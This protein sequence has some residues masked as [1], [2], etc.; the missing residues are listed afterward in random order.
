MSRTIGINE[1]EAVLQ[2]V[3]YPVDRDSVVRK[4]GDV[5]VDLAD[6]EVNL[7]DVIGSSSDDVFESVEDLELEIFS[8]LPREAVGE[9]FQSE[10]EG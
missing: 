1:I 9:P 5:T 2:E 3:E 8:L 4:F 7:G 6:G 10:G